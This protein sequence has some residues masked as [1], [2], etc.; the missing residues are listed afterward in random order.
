MKRIKVL[1]LTS[2][3]GRGGSGNSLLYLLKHIDRS[4]I[5]P[6]VVMPKQGVIGKR[7]AAE[8][9]RC[10]FQPRLRERLY[11]MRYRHT[12][13][14]TKILSLIRNSI[15]CCFFVGQF[16]ALI[17]RERAD[18]V[19]CNQMMVKLMG[20]A[21]GLLTGT[22][23][24]W[25]CRTIYNTFPQRLGF[26]LVARLPVVRRVV[27]VSHAAAANYPRL[28]KKVAVI[29]N[30]VDLQHFARNQVEGGLHNVM[31]VSED[32]DATVGFMGRVVRWKG[33]DKLLDA[34]EMVVASGQRPTFVIMGENPNNP[35]EDL[36]QMYKDNVQERCLS[37]R[38]LFAGFQKDV[39]PILMDVDLVVVPSIRPDPCPRS[40][41]ES[42]ALGVPVVGSD[43]GGIPELVIDGTTGLLSKAGD[44]SD[45]AKKITY[46]LESKSCRHKMGVAAREWVVRNHDASQVALR[47]QKVLIDSV[48]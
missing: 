26:N 34:A 13:S 29:H 28:S 19:H 6:V 10:V 22:P 30:G 18:L 27:A 40:V 9:V 12:N 31:K 39:R 41:L 16:A 3:T 7:L 14:L 21:A 36:L 17:S 37:K 45:L 35:S 20:A 47:I 5:E 8:G 33:I 48:Q 25:H 4:R 42:L 32:S 15:D 43:T 46:L 11:E 2:C 24:V 44:A 23:V 38:V 1:F